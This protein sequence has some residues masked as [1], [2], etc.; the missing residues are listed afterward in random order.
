MIDHVIIWLLRLAG[1]FW[2]GWNGRN[3]WVPWLLGH[4][5]FWIKRDIPI[6]ALYW[7][8]YGKPWGSHWWLWGI[9]AILHTF[10][11]HLF[12]WLGELAR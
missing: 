2:D 3:A 11:H 8:Q 9:F 6:I 12:Y 10:A 5:V 7:R 4:L 1:S